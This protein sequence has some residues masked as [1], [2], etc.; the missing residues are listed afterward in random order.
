MLY[1]HLGEWVPTVWRS[2]KTLIGQSLHTEF[3]GSGWS[4]S[5]PPNEQHRSLSY[6][7]RP[8]QAG[9][10]LTSAGSSRLR[11]RCWLKERHQASVY[12]FMLGTYFFTVS[13]FSLSHTP[14]SLWIYGETSNRAEQSH[15]LLLLWKQERVGGQKPRRRAPL[16]AAGETRVKYGGLEREVTRSQVRNNPFPLLVFQLRGSQ[17]KYR[18]LT[19][20]A[21]YVEKWAYLLGVGSLNVMNIWQT[22]ERMELNRAEG[23]PFSQ[24]FDC[25]HYFLSFLNTCSNSSELVLSRISC[26]SPFWMVS[27][28]LQSALRG[29]EAKSKEKEQICEQ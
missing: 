29:Y 19:F 25:I 18:T 11:P 24:C 26:L 9:L 7:V 27:L 12:P 5:F 21:S 28:R 20:C 1:G 10:L 2:L 4:M 23:K 13:S 15:G 3:N 6:R 22:V 16:K 8:L 14:S 17:R